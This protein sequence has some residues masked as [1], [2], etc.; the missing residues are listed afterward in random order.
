MYSVSTSHVS[1]LSGQMKTGWKE[2]QELAGARSRR[3]TPRTNVGDKPIISPSSPSFDRHACPV[4]IDSGYAESESESERDVTPP[5]KK[6]KV[7]MRCAKCQKTN[8]D[9]NAPK[10]H[11]V[12]TYP[13]PHRKKNPTLNQ[14]AKRQEKILLHEEMMER[15]TG[16]RT[17]NRVKI[18][19][20]EDHDFETVTR[21]KTFICNGKRHSRQYILTGVMIG[22]G[23]N[24]S[25]IGYN[26]VS[27]GLAR[28]RALRKKIED[29]TLKMLLPK[30]TIGD[31]RVLGDDTLLQEIKGTHRW[32]RERPR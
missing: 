14:V 28:D 21:T 5:L 22:A 6:R 4:H 25:A 9:P 32:G 23:M 24:S 7:S 12:P 29:V 3:Y 17:C 13:A 27:K 18:Y 11:I 19:F 8:L 31:H 26:T 10:F 16:F 15:V 30:V 1:L 20:C 2:L